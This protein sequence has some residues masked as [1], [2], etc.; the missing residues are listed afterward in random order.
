MKK[1]S[2]FLIFFI[3]L[4]SL[5]AQ[6]QLEDILEGEWTGNLEYLDYQDD[7]TVVNLPANLSVT[8]KKGTIRMKFGYLEPNGKIVRG[9][10]KITFSE[11]EI[12]WGGDP[13]VLIYQQ[14]NPEK[15]EGWMMVLRRLGE[16]NGQPA[17][18]RQT[19]IRKKDELTIFKEFKYEGSEGF[20]ARNRF[21]FT[22]KA[23]TLNK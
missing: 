14:G 18:L 22:K 5:Q 15:E 1:F 21:F 12:I 3:P 6:V 17:D 8:L 16:D 13:W 7:K 4:M 2:L 11:K 23:P 9:K 10:D 19:V 20:T